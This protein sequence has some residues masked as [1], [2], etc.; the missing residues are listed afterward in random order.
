MKTE[1]RKSI[2]GY[3][4]IAHELEICR[5]Y[6]IDYTAQKGRWKAAVERLHPKSLVTCLPFKQANIS[7][8]LQKSMGSAPAVL[9]AYRLLP[10]KLPIMIS[11][12]AGYPMVLCPLTCW[13]R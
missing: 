3:S 2:E 8:Y 1:V 11:P 5:K 7:T 12:C 4:Q 13:I 10:I 6:G 9:T